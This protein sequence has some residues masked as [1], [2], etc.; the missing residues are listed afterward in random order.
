MKN[1]ILSLWFL[2]SFFLLFSC[3]DDAVKLELNKSVQPNEIQPLSKTEYTLALAEAANVAET[4]SWKSPDYGFP[5]AGSYTLQLDKAGN[6]FA[7]AIDL[8]TT[9]N[10]SNSITVGELNKKLLDL[11]LSPDEKAD[12]EIRLRTLINDNV[13]V[14]YSAV[15]SFSVTPYATIFPP[16]YMIGDA[17]GGWDLAKAVK[18]KSI[19][20]SKYQTTAEFTNGGKFRFFSSPTWDANPQYNWT[21]F[22][23]GSVDAKLENGQD[24]DNN[25][26]FTG[27]TGWYLITADTKNKTITLEPKDQPRLYMIGAAIQGWDLGKAVELTRIEDGLFKA[28]TN[29]K[30]GE[31][32]RFFTAPD[33]S[34]GTINY[35]YFSGGHVD[36][37]FE[38][39]ADNDSNL[40]FLGE[41]G[42]YTITVDLNTLTIVME[43]GA[44]API[45]MI[46]DATGGWDLG[47]AVEV[48]K[49]GTLKYETTATFT[50]GG[51]FRFFLMPDWGATQY[52]WATF[53]GGIIDSELE[54]G[55]DNDGNFK[56]IGASGNYK[57]T[58]DVLNKSIVMELQ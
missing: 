37:L 10:L 45:Y 27:A 47:K 52:N 26:K 53:D 21:T 13:P 6:G 48:T 25:L 7:N 3:E 42:D 39:A 20:P 5:A 38:N 35:P 50:N 9:S 2:G 14:V 56:F 29:F 34:K 41:T 22:S 30:S 57:I 51:K 54:N 33:W 43:T 31:T 8:F 11:G 40:K 44:P 19:A 24:S 12:V 36:P 46:G 23:G 17:T 15:R 32:F 28:T 49:I 16:I 4:F 55:A 18:L 58:V 1:R